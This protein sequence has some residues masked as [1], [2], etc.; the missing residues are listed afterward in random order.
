MKR[1][2]R[3]IL[4]FSL[5]SAS[6]WLRRTAK[7]CAVQRLT[8]M[9]VVCPLTRGLSENKGNQQTMLTELWMGTAKSENKGQPTN[10]AHRTVDG[11]YEE[12]LRNDRKKS[13]TF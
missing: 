2:P 4:M 10:D 3:Y 9:A 11:N 13:W 6:N 1:H 5:F 8:M 12:Q 7:L